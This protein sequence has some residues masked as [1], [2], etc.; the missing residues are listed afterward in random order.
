MRQALA[1]AQRAVGQTYPNP[2]VGC[3]IVKDGKVGVLSLALLLSQPCGQPSRRLAARTG[4]G[5]PAAMQ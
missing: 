1:L 3:V 5:Q 4:Q 2:A